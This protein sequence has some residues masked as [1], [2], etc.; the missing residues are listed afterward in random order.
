MNS[1]LNIKPET[2]ELLEENVRK[3]LFHIGLGNSFFRYDT[4]SIS[5]KSKSK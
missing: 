5:N 1:D 2:I 3:R 4:K